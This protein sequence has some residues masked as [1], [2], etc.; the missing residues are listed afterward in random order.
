[1]QARRYGAGNSVRC[2]VGN[3]VHVSNDIGVDVGVSIGASI[4]VGARYQ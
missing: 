4:G 3:G 2:C 1:M